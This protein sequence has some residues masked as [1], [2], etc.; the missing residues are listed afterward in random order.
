MR[1]PIKAKRRGGQVSRVYRQEAPIKGWMA[2]Q[3]IAEMDADAAYQLDNWF[4]ETNSIVL[5]QGYSLH[6][7]VAGGGAVQTI[8]V[9]M[10]GTN[11]FAVANGNIYDVTAQVAAPWTLAYWGPF[12]FAYSGT[13]GTPWN[14]IFWGPEVFAFQAGSISPASPW[15]QAYWGPF[16]FAL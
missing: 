7:L 12:E 1:N 10:A 2:N 15:T 9:Y 14:Y 11:V 16:E 8:M 13:A 4:P 3:N 5:R 6:N